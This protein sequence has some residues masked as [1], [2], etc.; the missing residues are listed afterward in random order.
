MS[1]IIFVLYIVKCHP[2]LE[3]SAQIQNVIFKNWIMELKKT[4]KANLEKKRLLFLEIGFVL[5]LA[6]VLFAFEWTKEDMSFSSLGELPDLTG[7]EEII[8]ITRQELQKPP[9]PP[10]PQKVVLE[11]YIV[12]DDVEL[13][14]EF[15]IEDFEASQDE[16][17]EVMVMEEEEDEEAEVFYI[18]EDMP[19]FQGGGKEEFRS[20]IEGS[21]TYPQMAIENSISGT[22]YVSFVVNKKGEYAELTIMRG[23]DPSLNQAVL[24]AIRKAPKWKA[25]EQR[26]KPVDVRMAIPI[27]FVLN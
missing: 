9:E 11:L 13:E 3:G 27:K 23:V 16:E 22:V 10:K 24:D 12:E 14:D 6:L 18:V 19:T 17:I 2:R 25:G 21:M 8:P 20:Y 26:G 5:A 4:T 1:G 15:E 7:E